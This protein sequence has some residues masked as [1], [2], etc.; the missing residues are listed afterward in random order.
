MGYAGEN[1]NGADLQ[2]YL[3]KYRYEAS[4]YTIPVATIDGAIND[5]S[6]PVSWTRSLWVTPNPIFQGLE[7]ALDT[8]TAAGI[9]YPLPSR[10]PSC[11]FE[12]ACGF[13]HAMVG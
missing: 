2:E 8:Q 13:I 1:F 3:K 7:A 11:S 5:D 12:V 6:V 10:E 4:S 9:I